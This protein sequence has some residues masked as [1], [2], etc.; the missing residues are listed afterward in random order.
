MA[1]RKPR[2]IAEDIAEFVGATPDD[3]D[4]AL[5]AA[6]ETPTEPLLKHDPRTAAMSAIMEM[7]KKRAAGDG[8]G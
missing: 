6:L 2:K 5:D 1:A 7:A 3:A 4:E 8:K